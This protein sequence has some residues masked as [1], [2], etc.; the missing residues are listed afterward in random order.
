MEFLHKK[1]DEHIIQKNAGC[2]QQEITEQLHSSMQGWLGKHDMAHQK[3]SNGK[4]YT[5]GHD[6]GRRIWLKCDKAQIQHL[7]VQNK[8]IVN[9]KQTDIQHGIGTATCSI[10]ESL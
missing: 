2:Y 6:K 5:K 10:A 4:A 3:K 8:I 1:F 7:F 9:G